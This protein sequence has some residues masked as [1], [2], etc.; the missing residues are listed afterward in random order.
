MKAVLLLRLSL[1]L[2]CSTLPG[3]AAPLEPVR[4]DP[5]TGR[6]IDGQGR[7]RIFHGVNVVQKKPPWLPSTGAF[8]PK[9]SLDSTDMKLL[10]D[11]GFNLVRLGVMWPGVEV[12][13][14][15]Y[16]FDYVGR[17]AALIDHL[18]QHG[19]YT[20]ADLHQDLLSRHFCGE[21]V[22]E[23]YVEHLLANKSS[24][25]ARAAPFPMPAYRPL[26]LN[27]S[28][29]PSLSDCLSNQFDTYYRSERVGALF[30]EL[31]TP[32]TPL[33]TG[34]VDFWRAV[35]TQF[36]AGRSPSLLGYELMN[37]PS[38]QC[39]Q[40]PGTPRDCKKFSTELGTNAPEELLMAPLWRAAA[41]AIR[42][43]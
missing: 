31:F 4:V 21:G 34:F 5:Y 32:G 10:A 30:A 22:P 16:D 3:H 23:F 14:G 12:A 40:P 28:G 1:G 13:P 6:W 25:L 9:N 20:V 36:S 35:A 17:T 33:H 39:L 24:R 43:Q 37:E 18:A 26:K 42:E 41:S 2:Y 7:V 19:V 29:L 11:W 8:D 27:E 38:A 15:R